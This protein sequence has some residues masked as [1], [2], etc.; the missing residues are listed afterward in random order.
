MNDIALFLP[1]LL[2]GAWTTIWITFVSM[3]LALTLGLIIALARL[4]T[5][6]PSRW[7]AKAYVDFLRGTPL[8]LQLFYIYYVLPYV[9]IKMPA[10]VA[11]ILG[12]SLNYAA[13]L[14]E[15][16]RTSI[17]A[18]DKGQVEA[19]RTVGLRPLQILALVVMPQAMRIAIPPLGNYFIA[20]FK[21]TAL[22]AIISVK[23]LMFTADQLA[24]TTYQ[25]VAIYT[26]AFALYFSI[27]YPASLLV[28]R[29]E[30]RM[31]KAPR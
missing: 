30:R 1:P 20:L 25:Y 4:S 5:F 11:G 23:E 14:S 15:V 6:A 31:S 12:L 17:Q 9:G 24:S 7:L 10:I 19:A 27:S 18:V 2:L 16:Y 29:L 8:L 28:M 3:G 21:D 13:Y 26:L 22:V